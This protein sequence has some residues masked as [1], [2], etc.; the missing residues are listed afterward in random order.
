MM[1]LLNSPRAMGEVSSA[2]TDTPTGRLSKDR[3]SPWVAAEGGDVALDP[4]QRGDLVHVAI[5]A[6]RLGR[7]RSL[8]EGGMSEESI[9]RGGS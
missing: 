3:D 4:F 7:R 6:E 2:C 8:G 5:V 1:A 9:D